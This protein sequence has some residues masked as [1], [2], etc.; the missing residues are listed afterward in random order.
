MN[1]EVE[2]SDKYQ[3]IIWY[4]MCCMFGLSTSVLFCFHVYLILF[5][6]TTLG[7]LGEGPHP[8]LLWYVL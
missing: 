6:K 7:K 8:L 4:F 1:N 5:N 2:S 3:V